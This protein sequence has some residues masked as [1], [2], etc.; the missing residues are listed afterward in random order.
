MK[1]Y[2]N[3]I[4]KMMEYQNT[5]EADKML[6][7]FTD[8]AQFLVID[9]HSTFVEGKTNIKTMIETTKP[10]DRYHWTLNNMMTTDDKVVTF[11]TMTTKDNTTEAYIFIYEMKDDHI[12]KVW[13]TKQ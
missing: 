7:Y 4:T 9:D 12:N 3:I 2:K 8:D 1:D 5:Y 13:M 6:E 11:E 10:E